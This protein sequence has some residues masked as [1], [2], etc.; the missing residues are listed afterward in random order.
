MDYSSLWDISRKSKNINFGFTTKIYEGRKKSDFDRLLE[1]GDR[2]S[3]F[4]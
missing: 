3:D 1:Y 2:F 4:I